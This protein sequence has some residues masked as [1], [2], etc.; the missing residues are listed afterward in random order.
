MC[1]LLCSFQIPSLSATTLL[2]QWL[3]WWQDYILLPEGFEPLVTMPSLDRAL[4]PSHCFPSKLHKGATEGPRESPP[5]HCVAPLTWPGEW[6]KTATSPLLA[7]PREPPRWLPQLRPQ[8]HSHCVP[9][10]PG[11]LTSRSPM[12]QRQ[13][14]TCTMG[15]LALRVWAAPSPTPP[16]AGCV[17]LSL[18]SATHP[19]ALN[20]G[21]Q[22]R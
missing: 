10:E 13:T 17:I 7:L 20:P 2:G 3:T 1:F 18:L 4:H 8:W 16:L 12:L 21:P 19:P 6:V 15:P 5:P 22:C 11:P 14:H 9:L